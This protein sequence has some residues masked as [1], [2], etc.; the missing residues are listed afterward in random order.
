[1]VEFLA[2]AEDLYKNERYEE[3]LAAYEEAIRVAGPHPDPRLLYGRAAV[4]ERLAQQ[5]YGI[6]KQRGFD[7]EKQVEATDDPEVLSYQM[8]LT[9]LADR[10]M[11]EIE[12]YRLKEPYNDQYCLEIFHRA[13]VKHDSDAWELLQKRYSPTV[14][15]WMHNHP[16]RDM[17][18][19]LQ[20]EEDYV[21][22]TFVHV[23]QASTSNTL[24]FDSLAAALRYLKFSLQ[25]VIIDTQRAYSRSNEVPLPNPGSDTYYTEELATEDDYENNDLRETFRSLLPN[26]RERRLAN[27]LYINGL[28]AREIIHYLPEEFSDIQEVYR[29]TRNIVERLTRNRDQIRWRLEDSEP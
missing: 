4:L 8:S 22:E 6:A 7:D 23:W 5:S 25:A 11:R 14:R 28:K 17:A 26:E 20:P 24:E 2:Q 10:C 21:A 15:A 19:R 12:K 16:Q 9:A 1:M 18:C 13:L 27:L 29:L 3:A